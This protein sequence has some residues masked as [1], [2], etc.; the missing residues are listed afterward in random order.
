VSAA[1]IDVAGLSALT[2]LAHEASRGSWS[3]QLRRPPL[4]VRQLARL[5]GMQDLAR[6]A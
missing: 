6:A 4:V 3:L 2:S 5:V 1:L